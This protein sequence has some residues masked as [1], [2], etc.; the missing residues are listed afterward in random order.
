MTTLPAP[1]KKTVDI[2]LNNAPDFA[3]L[4]ILASKAEEQRALDVFVAVVY[5]TDFMIPFDWMSEFSGRQH[6]ELAD[7]STL[8]KA[9]AGLVRALLVANLR[10]DHFCTGHLEWLLHSG[11]LEAA[12]DRLRTLFAKP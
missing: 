2:I 3:T 11:Y 12:L 7:L 9:D 8:T 1:S 5:A 4:K 6:D 10:F